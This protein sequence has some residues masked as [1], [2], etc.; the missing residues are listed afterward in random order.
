MNELMLNHVSRVVALYL[1]ANA[2]CNADEMIEI[3]K[4][5]QSP[6]TANALAGTAD[7]FHN[8]S[9]SLVKA[10]LYDF[11]VRL[12]DLGVR[13]YPRNADLYADILKYG[14][15]C[16]N[17]TELKRYYEGNDEFSG[18]KNV[19]KRLWTWRSFSF[20]LDY[21]QELLKYYDDKDENY[22]KLKE[23]IESLLSEF[24]EYAQSFSDQS[25]HE[26]AYMAESE[27]LLLVGET[28]KAYEVLQKAVEKLPGRCPQCALRLADFYFEKAD[29]TNT[30]KYATIATDSVST[31]DAISVGYAFFILAI[32]MERKARFIDKI[33]LDEKSC[34]PIFKAYQKAYVDLQI[35]NRKTL[36]QSVQKKV[37][38]LE[39]E[40][41]VKSGI[42]F[43][44]KDYDLGALAALLDENKE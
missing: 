19:P 27:Y 25:E 20:L 8:A 9:V 38:Q 30:I 36:C 34:R 37:K 16:R 43:T 2:K 44:D 33:V 5:L 11:A 15:E 23:E 40:A 41:G 7:D 4:A 12:L 22:K 18:L 32:A 35:D 39:I 42:K 28:S 3:E 14:L 31:Q 21:L 13:K 10:N 1:R 26:K 29:Y 17:V 6:R 24:Y